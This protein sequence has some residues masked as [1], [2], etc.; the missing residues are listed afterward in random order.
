MLPLIYRPHWTKG[1]CQVWCRGRHFSPSLPSVR[2]LKLG[3]KSDLRAVVSGSIVWY[4]SLAPC[5]EVLLLW[6]FVGACAA[7]PQHIRGEN[8]YIG[9]TKYNTPLMSFTGASFFNFSLLLRSCLRCRKQVGNT[10]IVGKTIRTKEQPGNDNDLE[11]S[12]RKAGKL[13][14]TK[15]QLS[16]PDHVFVNFQIVHTSRKISKTFGSKNPTKRSFQTA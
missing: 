16:P 13:E 15:T 14:T 2:Y 7:T 8:I 5:S 6:Y 12:T 10:F 4:D 9:S 3:S 11:P 1:F